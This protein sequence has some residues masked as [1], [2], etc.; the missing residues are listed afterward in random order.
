MLSAVHQL[1]AAGYAVA[2]AAGLVAAWLLRKQL[3]AGNSG[4]WNL[5]KQNRR[6]RRAFPLAFLILATLAILGGAL[7][8]PSN[9]DA[10]AYRIPRVLHWLAAG[11][12][13]W[14]HTDFGRVNTRACGMEWL[15][16]PLIAF[17]RTDRT[18]FLIN[19]V[20]FLLLP[21]LIFSVFRRVGV[22]PRVAWHWMWLLPTGYCFLLQAGSISNDMFS[23]VYALAAVDF[24]LR[25]QESKRMS[26]ACLSVL[27]AALL[28]G[29]KTSNLPLLLPWAVALAPT[30]RL[31][32]AHPLITGA[33]VPVAFGASFLPMAILNALYGGDWTGAKVEHFTMGAGPV[34]LN[35]MA[36]GITCVLGNLAPPVFPPASAWNSLADAVTPHRIAA[37]VAK[38][39]FE[40][41]AAN[42]HLP[43]LQV[44]EQA[45]LGFGITLLLGLSLLAVFCGR[46]SRD[47]GAAGSV[48]PATRWVCWAP[49][50]SLLVLMAKLSISCLPR[51]VAPFYPLL[52]MG[53]LLGP[54]QG[55]LVRRGW[56]RGW[57]LFSCVMAAGLL[58]ISPARPLWPAG[59]FIEHYGARLQ[60]SRLGSMAM[61]AYQ[62]KAQRA[63]VFAAVIGRLPA[64]ARVLGFYAYDF[65][66]TALWKPFGS[67]RILH[68]SVNDSAEEIRRQGLKYLLLVTNRVKEPWPEWLHRMDA[69]DL[70]GVSLKMWGSLPPFE[71][72]LVALDPGPATPHIQKKERPPGPRSAN[73]P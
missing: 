65:P 24:A 20:S 26:E 63:D 68:V 45:G 23:A 27:S 18:L 41:A 46:G 48:A 6:F 16:A 39:G 44:E 51:Y 37:M 30:W 12:W 36:N 54:A 59:W 31:W 73:P 47:K 62:A 1:N 67:R 57:A 33:T 72:H 21:G 4:R 64:D 69:R 60:A 58:L 43:E 15:S 53:L 8:P 11:R 7:Y 70:D 38:Y 61:N 17:T 19:A 29:T 42:W 9:Y 49:W 2:F 3:F 40:P 56:W 25:A 22:G 66:E 10:M 13:H 14:L 5:R 28:T 55:A 35:L 52:V 32:L 34:W 50:I 71:W